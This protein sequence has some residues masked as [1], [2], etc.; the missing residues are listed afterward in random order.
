MGI[1]QGRQTDIMSTILTEKMTLGKTILNNHVAN[2]L[3]LSYSKMAKLY[4]SWNS[5]IGH[6]LDKRVKP[7]ILARMSD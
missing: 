5:T 2:K 6:V 7:G 4:I 3:G 1:D